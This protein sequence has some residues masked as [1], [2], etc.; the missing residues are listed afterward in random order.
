MEMSLAGLRRP[1]GA[2][3]LGGLVVY[4]DRLTTLAS[5]GDDASA[6]HPGGRHP[7][8]LEA[9]VPGVPLKHSATPAVTRVPARIR[10]GNSMM[11]NQP[12]TA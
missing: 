6:K 9:Q 7:P 3:N 1:L 5:R 2:V 4:F 12:G 10:H 11:G 8:Q